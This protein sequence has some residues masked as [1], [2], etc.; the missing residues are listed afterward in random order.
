MASKYFTDVMTYGELMLLNECKRFNNDF[1]SPLAPTAPIPND[2]KRGLIFKMLKIFNKLKTAGVTQDME[3]DDLAQLF[4]TIKILSRTKEASDMLCQEDLLKCLQIYSALS[5]EPKFNELVVNKYNKSVLKEALGCISNISFYTMSAVNK[6]VTNGLHQTLIQVIKEYGPGG[7]KSEKPLKN[8]STENQAIFLLYLRILFLFNTKSHIVRSHLLLECNAAAILYGVL[9]EVIK[10]GYSID[11]KKTN[12]MEVNSLRM[13]EQPRWFGSIIKI[14]LFDA[15][16]IIEI[17]K[18]LFNLTLNY[19]GQEI[20]PG[21]EEKN[22]IR[23]IVITRMILTCRVGVPHQAK[24]FEIIRHA[25]NA[26]YN[27]P[28]Y[29]YKYFISSQPSDGEM[30]ISTKLQ[31]DEGSN[32]DEYLVNCRT[33]RNKDMRPVLIMFHL[34]QHDLEEMIAD[35]L[36][37]SEKSDLLVPPMRLLS[38]I[39]EVFEEVRRLLKFII[40]PP[41]KKKDVV[42]LPHQGKTLRNNFTKVCQCT[43]TNVSSAAVNLLF[44]LCKKD[45]NRLIKQIGFG[46]SALLLS[47]NGLMKEALSQNKNDANKDNDIDSETEEYREIFKKINPVT[48][49]LEDDEK[50]WKNDVLDNMTDEQKEHEAMKLVEQIH[51]L[52]EEGLIKPCKIDESGNAVPIKH[53]TQLLEE[54]KKTKKK[55]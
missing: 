40:L 14:Q 5:P 32:V 9:N 51:K 2:I 28:E 15:D 11:L 35:D 27:I 19:S 52:T 36:L 47:Q 42:A 3:D 6:F 45:A 23:F 10:N 20:I 22:I 41:L 37:N 53:V 54:P 29:L 44:V 25:T 26:L 21:D 46:N 31:G 55:I 43:N 34:L 13:E 50:Y 39:S 16:V 38:R 33:Y 49:R 17:Y 1:I 30:M 48:C 7:K 8:M 24:S 18:S 4:T 12:K